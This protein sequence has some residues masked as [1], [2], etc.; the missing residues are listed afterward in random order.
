MLGK[1][2]TIGRLEPIKNIT[3]VCTIIAS[4]KH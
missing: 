4:I 2:Q 1:I 3:I